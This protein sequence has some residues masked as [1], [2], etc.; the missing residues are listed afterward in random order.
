M[1]AASLIRTAPPSRSKVVGN[2][3]GSIAPTYRANHIA[4]NAMFYADYGVKSC[5]IVAACKRE[6]VA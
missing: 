1:D 4:V 2:I 3:F 6:T 5:S